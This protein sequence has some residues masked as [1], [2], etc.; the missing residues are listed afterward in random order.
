MSHDR[1]V[2]ALPPDDLTAGAAAIGSPSAF[3]AGIP[4]VVQSLRYAA[5]NLGLAKGAR[6]LKQLNQ[7]DGYDCPGCAWPD[8]PAGERSVA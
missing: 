1:N 4:A 7:T 8:P 3:A 2:E 6:L 5:K